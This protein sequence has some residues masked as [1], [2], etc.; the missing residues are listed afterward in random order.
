MCGRY[1]LTRA[2]KMA[3]KFD[4]EFTGELRPRYNIAPAQPVWNERA[5]SGT[6]EAG[7]GSIPTLRLERVPPSLPT[8]AVPE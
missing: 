5:I 4:A 1:R 6:A 8:G 3:R 7:A 2:E